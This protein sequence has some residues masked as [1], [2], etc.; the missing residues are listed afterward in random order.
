MAKANHPEGRGGRQ[1]GLGQEQQTLFTLSSPRVLPGADT[2]ATDPWRIGMAKRK[3]RLQGKPGWV[4]ASL[5]GAIAWGVVSLIAV[6][7]FEVAV[8]TALAVGVAAWLSRRT[9]LVRDVLL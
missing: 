9:L 6:L 1:V 8:T 3:R 7:F 5:A 4:I 2:G